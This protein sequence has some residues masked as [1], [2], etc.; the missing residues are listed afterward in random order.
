M[1]HYKQYIILSPN[2]ANNESFDAGSENAVWCNI[3]SQSEHWCLT[4]N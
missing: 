2:Q 3:V 4:Y 1:L